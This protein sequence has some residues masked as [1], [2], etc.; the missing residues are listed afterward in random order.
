MKNGNMERAWNYVLVRQLKS[1]PQ[2]YPLHLMF[3]FTALG[4]CQM[5]L[6]GKIFGLHAVTVQ[7]LLIKCWLQIPWKAWLLCEKLEQEFEQEVS[8]LELD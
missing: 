8:V 2:W 1:M 4:Q 5:G 3:L 6:R 7:A